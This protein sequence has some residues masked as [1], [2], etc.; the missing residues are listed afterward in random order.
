MNA[1][2][3]NTL[4]DLHAAT[5]ESINQTLPIPYNNITVPVIHTELTFHFGVLVGITG[6]IKGKVLFLADTEFFS[7][8]GELMFGM[9]LEGEMLKSFAGELGNMISGGLCSNTFARGMSI[10][11]T[12]PTIM[13]GSTALSGFKEAIVVEMTFQNGKKLAIG[14]MID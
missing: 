9:A 5:I 2:V 8:V 3:S 7:S 12:S 1:T 10:D 13:E 11:I 14:L 6:S 4:E